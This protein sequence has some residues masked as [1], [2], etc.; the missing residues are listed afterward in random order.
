MF[1]NLSKA[2]RLF[3]NIFSSFKKNHFCRIEKI[4]LNKNLVI[5]Y[6]KGVRALIKLTL[7]DLIQDTILLSSFP[8]K[9]AAW[10]G[11]YYGKYYN[12]LLKQEEKQSI[13]FDFLEV[14]GW[15]KFKIVMITR[16]GDITYLDETTNIFNTLH[17]SRIIAEKKLIEKFE[18]IQ[19]C[20]IGILSGISEA[21]ISSIKKEL[22][23]NKRHLR[24]VK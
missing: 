1:I 24:L 15:G 9:H 14:K 22:Q 21:K 16:A 3:F 23:V 13:S 6:C 4:D 11:F 8:P 2:A 19:A 5:V 12:K 17:P 18:P 10:I 7:K 20:Y